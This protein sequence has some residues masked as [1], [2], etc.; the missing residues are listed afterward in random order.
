MQ[1]LLRFGDFLL[2]LLLIHASLLALLLYAQ[3]L[4]ASA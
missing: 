2:N 3:D 4:S 1:G